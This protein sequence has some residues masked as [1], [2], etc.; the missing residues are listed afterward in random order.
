MSGAQVCVC[1]YVELLSVCDGAR[2]VA[3]WAPAALTALPQLHSGETDVV[4]AAWKLQKTERKCP[5]KIKDW[6]LFHA[7]QIA[8]VVSRWGAVVKIFRALVRVKTR[9]VDCNTMCFSM[10]LKRFSGQ[11]TCILQVYS[12]TA[13]RLFFILDKSNCDTEQ[14]HM[15]AHH[16]IMDLRI[17]TGLLYPAVKCILCIIWPY[18][19]GMFWCS[20]QFVFHTSRIFTMLAQNLLLWY[21]C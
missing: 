19:C 18:S 1:V 8:Y 20:I 7:N 6:T 12:E 11:A 4:A 10:V 5:S 17:L 14:D 13:K 2:R 16:Y 15:F 3:P 9:C 21:W